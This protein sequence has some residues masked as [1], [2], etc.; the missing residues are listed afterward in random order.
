MKNSRFIRQTAA[1]L[2]ILLALGWPPAWSPVFQSASA[3]AAEPATETPPPAALVIT[4]EKAAQETAGL[5]TAPLA[6]VFHARELRAYGTV[7]PLQG[8]ADLGRSFAQ[9]RAQVENAQARLKASQAEYARLKSLHAQNQN[10]SLK[11]LQA[12]ESTWREDRNNLRAAEA[13][14]RA[15]EGAARQQ[16]G[17]VIARWVFHGAPAFSRLIN[18]EEFLV[19]V[20][21]PVGEKI[22]PMPRKITIQLPGQTGLAARLLSPAPR[23]DPQIQGW[24]FFYA[25]SGQAGQLPA[26]M[27]IVAQLP[28]G[29]R[30]K[31][32]L[33]PAATVVWQNGQA[34]V[35]V[36]TGPERFAARP[37][38]TDNLLPD[39]YFVTTGF[40]AGE[41]LVVQ[42]A[43]ALLSE[44]SHSRTKAGKGEADE[45]GD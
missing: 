4:L 39:G 20:T 3:G 7:L 41:R 35:F 15:L 19:Q 13:S 12:A 32:F 23:L 26:G 6:Q 24:S 21:L 45:E 9:A 42:G 30:V 27:N 40:T 10:V 38:A 18:Q 29:P 2:L 14:Q 5:V 34:M 44:A 11:A 1:E 43:Q 37:V 33:I 31:G 36:Q 28:A 16:W 17:G 22:A 8:L 25:V